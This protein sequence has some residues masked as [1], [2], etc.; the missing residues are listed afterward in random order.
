MEELRREISQ[1]DLE[2]IF[3]ST[4]DDIR[5]RRAKEVKAKE[6]AVLPEPSTVNG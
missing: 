2:T 3:L 5:E 1:E 4:A 6:I